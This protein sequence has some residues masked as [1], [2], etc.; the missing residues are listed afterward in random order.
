MKIRKETKTTKVY[1]I[2]GDYSQVLYIYGFALG[3]DI[4]MLMVVKD[5]M[6][7]K[8]LYVEMED[9][10]DGGEVFTILKG[11]SHRQESIEGG[12]RR[13]KYYFQENGSE[14]EFVREEITWIAG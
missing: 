7:S 14:I 3:G 9:Y 2:T 4:A 11:D 12:I 5:D 8:G 10:D 6:E 13:W 1:T